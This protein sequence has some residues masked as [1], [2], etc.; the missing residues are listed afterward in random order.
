M[1]NSS[2]RSLGA[3]V[4]VVSSSDEK[5]PPENIID[6]NTESFWMSTGLFPQEFII[7]FT[8][9][10]NISAVTMD[11]YNVKHLKLEKNTSQSASQFE[12]VTE[13]EFDHVTGCLQS[14]TLPVNGIVATHLR[15]I[16]TSGHDHF[17]SVHR[18]SVQL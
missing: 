11:S 17:V 9:S 10:T 5:H 12:S 1:E 3:K 6:G 2:L 4:V 14:N 16:I 7:G 15:F 13:K 8:H 18:V